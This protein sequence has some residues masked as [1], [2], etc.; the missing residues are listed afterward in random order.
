M[1]LSPGPAVDESPS[2]AHYRPNAT[3]PRRAC[4]ARSVRRRRRLSYASLPRHPHPKSDARATIR[5]ALLAISTGGMRVHQLA[6]SRRPL[7]YA[8]RVGV[9]A[10]LYFVA[11]KL[12]LL[13]AIPP[14]YATAVW[15]PSG[16]AVAAMLLAGNRLWP[17]VWLGVGAIALAG[18]KGMTE[19]AT[20]WWT[21]WQGD[22]TGIIVFAP[23][24]LFWTARPSRGLSASKKIEAT[25]FALVLA[26]AGYIVF[27]SGMA[28]LGFSPAL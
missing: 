23:V 7:T 8:A 22:V 24:I 25:L 2:P 15:P 11:A 12:S 10:A 20:N 27:G 5:P 16:L 1:R 21:W 6:I 28:S 3:G 13:L 19:F 17:G 9:L 4:A 26:A 14:G 18:P